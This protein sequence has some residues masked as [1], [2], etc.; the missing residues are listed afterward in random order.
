M[1]LDKAKKASIIKDF[2]KDKNDTGSVEVQVA[3]L[4]SE[5]NELTEH[6]KVHTHD[7][8]SKLGLLK[9]VGKRKSLLNYLKNNDVKRYKELIKKL[10]LR[11]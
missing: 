2:G 3:I 5:I 8:H 7:Y 11:K 10:N 4:T 6:M 9:K 1:A